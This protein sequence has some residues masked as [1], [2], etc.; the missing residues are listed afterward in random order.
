MMR[1]A[2]HTAAAVDER[3]GQARR[4]GDDTPRPTPA[5]AEP[6]PTAA[7]HLLALWEAASGAAPGARDAAVLQAAGAPAATSLGERNAQLLVLHSGLFGAR[8]DLLS[9][10]P[11][12]AAPAEFSVDAAAL[13]QGIAVPLPTLARGMGLHVN[14]AGYAVSF[15]LPLADDLAF[16]A[17]DGSDGETFA[18]HLMARVVSACTC[19]GVPVPAA[20]LARAAGHLP[21]AV[22]DAISHRIEAVDPGAALSFD[23]A[24]PHCTTHWDAPFDPAALLWRSLQAAA[25][26]LL[27]EV[28]ALAR[29]YGWTEGDVLALSPQRRAAYLQL[30]QA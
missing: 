24:C 29:A 19:D 7:Q 21:L 8:I 23:V 28:D 20:D 6:E 9:H 13:A 16:A 5:A 12:C 22:I 27:L 1:A 3:R 17:A 10:C 11:G 14:V 26:R 25:E 2:I 18:R 30:A 4:A 15:R